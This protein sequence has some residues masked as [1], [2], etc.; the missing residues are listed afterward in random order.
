MAETRGTFFLTLDD[1]LEKF[2]ALRGLE[3]AAF[4]QSVK[5]LANALIALG[6]FQSRHDCFFQNQLAKFHTG[7]LF[8]FKPRCVV[9]KLLKNNF[10]KGFE[11]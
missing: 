10:P 8:P 3:R 7:D 2:I 4:H 11:K 1:R 9:G 5:K 6:R